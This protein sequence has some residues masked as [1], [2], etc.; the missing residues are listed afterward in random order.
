MSRVRD[1]C[2]AEIPGGLAG[3]GEEVLHVFA[4]ADAGVL[5]ERLNARVTHPGRERDRAARA[6]GLTGVDEMAAAAAR[7]PDGTLILRSDR[8]TPAGLAGEVPARAG[9]RQVHGNGKRTRQ[10]KSLDSENT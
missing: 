6:L 10:A 4:E 3:A 9:S 2:R 7:Q 1:A 5:R 8:L